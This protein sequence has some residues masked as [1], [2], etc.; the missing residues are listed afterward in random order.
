[1][2]KFLIVPAILLT[3]PT[4]ASCPLEDGASCS[5]AQFTRQQ[6]K[7]TYA[8]NSI[9]NDYS[10]TPETR[11]NPSRNPADEEGLQNFGNRPRNFSYNADCQFGI[12]QK[13]SGVPQLFENR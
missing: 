11:L 4:F 5:V 12:C 3:L 8:Q 1:M 2:K 13:S 9:I 7:P 6:L 10:E